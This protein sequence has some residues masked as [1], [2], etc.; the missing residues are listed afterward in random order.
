MVD[1]NREETDIERNHDAFMDALYWYGIPTLFR[2]PFDPDPQ[3]CDIALVGVPHS[4]GNGTTERDQH[5][6]PRAVRDVSANGRRVHM[7]YELDPWN[8]CTVRDLGDVP[9]THGNNNEKSI[10]HITDFYRKIDAVGARPVSVGGDHSI[11]GGILQALGGS[12]SRLT[13]G[14]KVC[15]LHF[16]AHTDCF[17]NMKHFLGAEKSAAHWA[18]YLERD[19][20]VD[21]HHSVQVG[22]RGNA[23]TLDWLKPSYEH[24]YE[25]ITMDRYNEI[26]HSESAEIIRDRI[27]NRP[28]YI[29]FDL[30]CLDPTVA[31]GVSNIEAGCAGFMI[32]QAVSLIQSVRGCNVIGGDVVCLIPTKDS[33]NKITSMVAMSV[34]FEII[35]LIADAKR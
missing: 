34:M 4:T 3:N 22:I 32:D 28:L 24:G 16:D 21:A 33:P 31:P 12:E 29:T 10:E 13:Q 15:I 5:L 11:T 17:S 8:T 6:G 25:V 9:L 23:R 27:G 20:H 1:V 7:K 26:G 18:S 14:E 2:A 19:G 35:S 30:D